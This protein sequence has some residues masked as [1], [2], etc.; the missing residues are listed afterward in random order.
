MTAFWLVS[1]L[2][3]LHDDLLAGTAGR[4][5]NGLGAVAVLFVTLTGLAIWW[6]GVERW[7]R[8]LTVRRGVGWKR[9]AWDLHSAIGFWSSGF[10]LVS[11]LSGVYLCFPEEL[12]TVRRIHPDPARV[13]LRTGHETPATAAHHAPASGRALTIAATCRVD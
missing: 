11:A 2:I 7:R 6:P 5:L 13:R 3:E 9:F 10:V 1:K 8:S 12:Q 4:R